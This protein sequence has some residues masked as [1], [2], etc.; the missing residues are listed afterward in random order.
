MFFIIY[1]VVI[2]NRLPFKAN[3]KQAIYL[4]SSLH[5]IATSCDNIEREAL[6]KLRGDIENSS[7]EVQNLFYGG[8]NKQILS[9][10]DGRLMPLNVALSL[11]DRLQLIVA[12]HDNSEY[13]SLRELRNEIIS[14]PL[15]VQKLFYGGN[16]KQILLQLDARL[17]SLSMFLK[18]NNKLN[19]IMQTL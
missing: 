6:I 15:E 2:Y 11:R 12:S 3:F 17:T 16:N 8:N 9:Q 19:L 10:I 5:K 4:E 1:A 14:A 18:L 7:L 13:N